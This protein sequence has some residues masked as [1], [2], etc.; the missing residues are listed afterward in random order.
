[1][2]TQGVRLDRLTMNRM[3]AIEAPALL[4]KRNIRP[5]SLY[6]E[7][8]EG[9]FRVPELFRADSLGLSTFQDTGGGAIYEGTLNDFFTGTNFS[10]GLA[11]R[12]KAFGIDSSGTRDVVL[13][14]WG[15]RTP[16]N[17]EVYVVAR[18]TG[19]ATPQVDIVASLTY[20]GAA[21]TTTLSYTLPAVPSPGDLGFIWVTASGANLTL[22]YDSAPGASATSRDTA[23]LGGAKTTSISYEETTILGTTFRLGSGTLNTAA[24]GSAP[25]VDQVIGFSSAIDAA[26]AA[27]S[28]IARIP[29]GTAGL[30]FY[31]NGQDAARYVAS[32]TDL[33]DY[34]FFLYPDIPVWEDG[35]GTKFSG[36]GGII[37]G[38]N[39]PAFDRF[40][41]TQSG[42]QKDQ[43]WAVVVDYTTPAQQLE[44]Y[45]DTGR[46]KAT[47]LHV[48]G[49]CH[50]YLKYNGATGYVF[51]A[52]VETG[53]G[54]KTVTES[55]L[56][57]ANT[58]YLFSV[59]RNSAKIRAR[60]GTGGGTEVAADPLGPVKDEDYPP[61]V[62]VGAW[63]DDSAGSSGERFENRLKGTVHQVAL[64]QSGVPS[65]TTLDG[66][67]KD[68]AILFWDFENNG[69]REHVEDAGAYGITGFY[70]IEPQSNLQTAPPFW[71][72]GPIKDG[73][74]VGAGGGLLAAHGGPAIPGQAALT[75]IDSF[76]KAIPS[77][78][79]IGV[80]VGRKV[81]HASSD[82]AYVTD[83]ERRTM[84]PL[85]LPQPTA[86]PG[87]VEGG[88]GV[89]DGIAAWGYR[90]LSKDGTTSAPIILPP[91]LFEEASVRIG[92]ADEALGASYGDILVPADGAFQLQDTRIGGP[93]FT[94]LTSGE[95]TIEA[96]TR[97]DPTLKDEDLREEIWERRVDGDAQGTKLWCRQNGVGDINS[98]GNIT[99]QVAFE[100]GTPNISDGQNETLLTIGRGGQNGA[101]G[102]ALAN[103]IVLVIRRTAGPN[104]SLRL[105][106]A[107]QRPESATSYTVTAHT[108]VP[109]IVGNFYNILVV[110]Q[111]QTFT[112]YVYERTAAGAESWT[113]DATTATRPAGYPHYNDARV[114]MGA[115]RSATEPTINGIT[116]KK[117][118]DSHSFSICRV[119]EKALDTN[120]IRRTLYRRFD[121]ELDPDLLEDLVKEFQWPTDDP[122]NDVQRCY[123][124]ISGFDYQ[125]IR[126][127]RTAGSQTTGAKCPQTWDFEY[128]SWHAI[129]TPT[130]GSD[131][132]TS[133]LWYVWTRIG[134]GGFFVGAR[135][136][137]LH[138]ELTERLRDK[139]SLLSVNRRAFNWFTAAVSLTDGA[140]PTLTVQDIWINGERRSGT[141]GS[142]HARATGNIAADF[143][144]WANGSDS[145]FDS[146]MAELRIWNSRRY[147][148]PGDFDYLNKRV[149]PGKYEDLVYYFR[150]TKT[151]E[152]TSGSP[153]LEQTNL[154]TAV[155]GAENLQY[156]LDDAE[157]VSVS[158]RELPLAPHPDIT[159]IQLIR[160]AV[161]P[162][163]D[164]LDDEEIERKKRIARG[165]PFFLL[166]DVP[167]GQSSYLDN[168][169]NFGLGQI[170][171][172]TTGRVPGEVSTIAAW[173]DHMVIVEPDSDI[174]HFSERGPQGFESYPD[175]LRYQIQATGGGGITALLPF[176]E[177]LL[178]YTAG[179]M[180]A[181]SGRP[182]AVDELYLGD[183]SGAANSRCAVSYGGTAYSF[184][185]S[186]YAYSSREGARDISGPVQDLLPTAA[187]GRLAIST[188]LASLLVIDESTGD[189]LRLHLPS[190]EWFIEDRYLAGMTDYAG[191]SY[192][193]HKSGWVAYTDTTDPSDDCYSGQTKSFAPSGGGASTFIIASADTNVADPNV[194]GQY[195]DYNGQR[196][197]LIK[198]DGTLGEGEISHH[199]GSGPYTF[200][201]KAA[202]T[203]GLSAAAGDTVV[204][205]ITSDGVLF[206]TGVYALADEQGG[207]VWLDAIEFG[208]ESGTWELATDG[209]NV[210]SNPV[211][212][213]N[214]TTWRSFATSESMGV[215]Q[216]ARFWRIA[217][218]SL[219]PT[220]ARL[221]YVIAMLRLG[222]NP[223]TLDA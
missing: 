105:C 138:R 169:P 208:R 86:T 77:T 53:N 132:T 96:L 55:T 185:G 73:R 34:G 136:E 2:A 163:D 167:V 32:N 62:F 103:E 15:D 211:A 140:S 48:V 223:E 11:V 54:T 197:V 36:S 95:F 47:L 31:F 63:R 160:S 28:S 164:P 115:C 195:W 220:A 196:V 178:A 175:W 200:T 222:A 186:L 126:E 118:D 192:Y 112:I 79:L 143:V 142:A 150:M 13:Y 131:Y 116:T 111:G 61:E 108:S 93:A 156:T 100:M 58:R 124:S 40:F 190:N 188:D 18:I 139:T 42:Y 10:L 59:T 107:N 80:R 171:D 127:D 82:Y 25:V 202:W 221:S 154:G 4:E 218:R 137:L 187:N 45:N 41:E 21:G 209:R 128:S 145:Q 110:G 5:D 205:G 180:V 151:D 122:F 6:L 203:G 51:E 207:K 214:L 159:N 35:V 60:V 20:T 194:N 184:N 182:G 134:N 149:P 12:Y 114:L 17:G 119:W 102:T 144:N 176:G 9:S 52:T 50:L 198:A 215:G 162:V 120:Q 133:P 87:I 76:L 181:L 14:R 121:P 179:G 72:R 71:S 92:G 81:F 172:E 39:S 33:N 43:A 191:V 217:F 56:L 1:M 170:V 101:V 158:A 44:F 168:Q 8:R 199:T 177:L 210:P 130:S 123:E 219:K 66:A 70:E 148:Q 152:D 155:G 38:Y 91:K 78:D 74:Y 85:G 65:L 7:S 22:Y 141:S 183:G 88:P 153:T 129:W 67:P 165:G 174:L 146:Q 173:Q 16:A 68:N 29:S 90:W 30:R 23:V 83:V 97:L 189:T 109:L 125:I 204:F 135:K 19:G 3:P 104:Y 94:A 46:T 201:L 213:T 106:L 216:Q 27:A 69:R 37:H 212:R 193:V 75:E 26:T 99:G 206:D 49:L 117:L 64:Y 161:I 166:A 147:Q 89:I 57:A 24:D 157:I 113:V 84:R 98:N